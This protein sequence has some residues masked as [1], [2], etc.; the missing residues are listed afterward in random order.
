MDYDVSLEL[1]LRS[2]GNKQGITNQLKL[3][4]IFI[5]LSRREN[6]ISLQTDSTVWRQCVHHVV[7]VRLCPMFPPIMLRQLFPPHCC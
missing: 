4:M 2:L 7:F 1:G 5:Q 3:M 6:T